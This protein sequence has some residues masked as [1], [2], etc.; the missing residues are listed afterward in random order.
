MLYPEIGSNVDVVIDNSF[1][2]SYLAAD[3]KHRAQKQELIR[4]TVFAAPKWASDHLCVINS[5]TKANNYIPPHRILSINN[6]KVE[7]KAVAK[8]KVLT[9]YSSKTGE[10]YTVRQDGRTGKW[11]CTCT[12][13][14]F[15]KKCRHS[16]RAAEAA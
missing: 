1:V 9:V 13:F 12:G 5:V 16:I 14:Q 7:Q 2:C 3:S 10:P 8:D 11:S 6:T 15:H 4:G